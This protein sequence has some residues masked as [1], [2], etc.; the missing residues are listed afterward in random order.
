MDRPIGFF[1]FRRGCA[2]G[3]YTARASPHR[4]SWV[5]G[6]VT[7]VRGDGGPLTPSQPPGC[8]GPSSA[9]WFAPFSAGRGPFSCPL[10][11]RRWLLLLFYARF[12]ASAPW[13]QYTCLL[14][15]RLEPPSG[16]RSLFLV[17]LLVCLFGWSAAYLSNHATCCVDLYRCAPD[18]W[19]CA[20]VQPYTYA[21]SCIRVSENNLSRQFV[22]RGEPFLRSGTGPV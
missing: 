19:R 13:V 22:N 2:G 16:R 6:G 7:L 12:V 20:P 18:V 9:Q 14:D 3:R 17:V 8:L 15:R 5:A 1:F 10:R 4:W 21:T 11:A